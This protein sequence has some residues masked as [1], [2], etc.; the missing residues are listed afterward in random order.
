MEPNLARMLLQKRKSR[1]VQIKLP[2]GRA[3]RETLMGGKCK[4]FKLFL[5]G[6]SNRNSTIFA[7]CAVSLE[8]VG[9]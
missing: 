6:T 9:L 5:L 2:W 1:S 8:Y 3:I 4:S 7:G